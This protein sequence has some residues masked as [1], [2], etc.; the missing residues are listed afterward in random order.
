[1]KSFLWRP[2]SLWALVPLAVVMLG[3]SLFIAPPPHPVHSSGATELQV[4]LFTSQPPNPPL[5]AR[6][7][8]SESL[9][10]MECGL[11]RR[12]SSLPCD[13]ADP[14]W[15]I[16]PTA[17]QKPHTLYLLWYGCLDWSGA[18]PIIPWQGFNFEYLPGSRTVVAHCYKAAPYLYLPDRLYGVA[19]IPPYQLYAM[20]DD[21]FGSGTVTIQEDDRL[22]HLVGDQSLSQFRLASAS[23]S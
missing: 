18:G 13:P 19:A 17:A 15:R 11:W 16:F 20:P 6:V 23:V 3:A 8:A 12:G 4:T 2:R 21:S 22:E 10:V 7:T 1:M 5:Y 9:D 14:S